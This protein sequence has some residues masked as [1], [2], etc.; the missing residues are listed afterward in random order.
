MTTVGYVENCC[1]ILNLTINDIKSWVF[2]VSFALSLT[3]MS[4]VIYLFLFF[5]ETVSYI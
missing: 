1:T 4:A 3:L 2:V 5:K